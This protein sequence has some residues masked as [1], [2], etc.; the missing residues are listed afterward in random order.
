MNSYLALIASASGK[1][2]KLRLVDQRLLLF[3]AVMI[4]LFWLAVRLLG[5]AR[6]NSLLGRGPYLGAASLTQ[7]DVQNTARM[8]NVAA[9]RGLLGMPCL[10]TALFLQWFLRR[11]GVTSH[12]RIGVRIVAGALDAHAWVECE[13][14]P[15]NDRADIAASFPPIADFSPAIA[16]TKR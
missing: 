11:H 16:S 14:I 15:I 12:V 13:G 10:P 7:S 5:L 4:P 8:V 3:A 9:R 1:F 6:F 2:W